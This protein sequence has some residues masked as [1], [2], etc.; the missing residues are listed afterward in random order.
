MEYAW[1]ADMCGVVAQTNTQLMTL[2]N[3][4]KNWQQEQR[5]KTVVAAAKEK[6]A[7]EKAAVKEKAAAVKAARVMA[8]M[9]DGVS[10]SLLH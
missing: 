8:S 2:D 3:H 7:K 4:R 6:A 5:L 10:G 1:C 9:S